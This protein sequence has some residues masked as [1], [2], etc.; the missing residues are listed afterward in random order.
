MAL[1]SLV[2][3]IIASAGEVSMKVWNTEELPDHE[4]FVYRREVLCEAS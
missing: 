2:D 3:A 1:A 4:Q